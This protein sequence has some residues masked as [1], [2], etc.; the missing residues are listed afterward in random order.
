MQ[1]KA[2]LCCITSTYTRT[3]KRLQRVKCTSQLKLSEEVSEVTSLPPLPSLHRL[4]FFVVGLLLCSSRAGWGRQRDSCRL[5]CRTLTTFCCCLIAFPVLLPRLSF[6]FSRIFSFA[7]F[8]GGVVA[9]FVLS[10]SFVQ[11]SHTPRTPPCLPFAARRVE[12]RGDTAFLTLSPG[13]AS[14]YAL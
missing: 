9:P 7:F 8:F 11:Q 2:R 13:R 6:S 3:Q 12:S 5:R 4:S 10:R 14:P 1:L